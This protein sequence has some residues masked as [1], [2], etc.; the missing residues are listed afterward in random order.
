MLKYI[1]NLKVVVSQAMTDL[2]QS[3]KQMNET[4]SFSPKRP[5]S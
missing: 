2:L 3:H 1:A 4:N 5:Y